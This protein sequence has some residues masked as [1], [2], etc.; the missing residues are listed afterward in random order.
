[1]RKTIV[2]YLLM[3]LLAL[4]AWGYTL[5]GTVRDKATGVAVEFALV[6]LSPGQRTVL[7]DAQG[8]YTTSIAAGN[9]TVTVSFIGYK[10]VTQK[11]TVNQNRTLDFYL[12]ED[13]QLLDEVVVTAK[14]QTGLT[15]TS[16]IDRDAMA[17]LQPTSFTDLLELLPGNISQTP[18]MGSVNSI[19]LRETG[20]LTASGAT[21]NSALSLWWTA[22]PSMATP[23]CRTCLEQAATCQPPR[24]SAT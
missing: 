4:P 13:A 23:I 15:S 19:Q 6:E 20:N 21:S 16:R 14:E 24:A 7:T 12:E 22:H 10:T 5:R 17:H 11:I 3:V 18:E 2:I 9:F 8:H 1:M